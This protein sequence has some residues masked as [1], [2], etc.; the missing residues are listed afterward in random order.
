MAFLVEGHG[1]A[2][3]VARVAANDNH[4]FVH[5]LAV[6]SDLRAWLRAWDLSVDEAARI[7]PSYCWTAAHCTCK[8]VGGAQTVLEVEDG[9]VLKVHGKPTVEKVGD[10]V[11]NGGPKRKGESGGGSYLVV[12]YVVDFDGKKERRLEWKQIAGGTVTCG[13]IDQGVKKEH[14]IR[15][16]LSPSCASTLESI[17]PKYTKECRPFRR[18]AGN[19]LGT[20]GGLFA[21]ALGA[22]VWVRRRREGEH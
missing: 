11:E 2:H 14:A 7:Q 22:A 16:L 17:D 10:L 12:P 1:G 8:N 20:I 19:D 21:T 4:G 18:H 13:V 15:A 5:T 9:R 3:L 6:D